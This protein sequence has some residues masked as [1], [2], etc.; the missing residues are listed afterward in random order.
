MKTKVDKEN[1]DLLEKHKWFIKSN[2]YVTAKIDGKFVLL[3]RLI[4]KAKK[5]EYVDHLNHDKLDN[6]KSNLRIC[7]QS[8]NM[9]NARYKSKYPGVVWNKQNKNWNLRLRI[10]GKKTHLGTFADIDTAAKA[11]EDAL[12]KYYGGIYL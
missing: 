1:I 8:E 12:S 11:R 10:N 5:G 4:M 3:H 6:R 2:G 9:H 7:T